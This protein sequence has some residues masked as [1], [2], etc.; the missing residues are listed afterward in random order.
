MLSFDLL[1][2]KQEQPQFF[3]LTYT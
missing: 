1:H 3:R 2:F